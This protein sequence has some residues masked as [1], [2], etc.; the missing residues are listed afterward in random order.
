MKHFNEEFRHHYIY[1]LKRFY[2]NTP[3]FKHSVKENREERIKRLEKMGFNRKKIVFVNHHL[4]HASA[5]YFSSPWRDDALVLTLDGSGDGICSAV[6]I[7]DN[8]ELKKIAE[9]PQYHSLGSI[10]SRS[11]FMLGMVPWEHEYK[12]M[13]LAPYAKGGKQAEGAYQKFKEYLDLDPKNPLKFKRKIPEPTIHIYRRFMKDFA[14]TRFDYIAY[15]LQKFTEE[16]IT[17]WVKEAIKRT[18]RKRVVLGGGVF[19][20]VKANKKVME[21]PEVKELFIMPSCGDETNSI[22][23]AY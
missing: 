10:Y 16:M 3:M 1:F 18:G 11:T 5:A 9:T 8:G 20:N 6:W 21:I 7:A 4:S 23:A 17:K 12:V 14:A 19:M 22:G 2:V 13:G 15:G